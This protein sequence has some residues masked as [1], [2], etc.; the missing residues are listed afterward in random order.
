[1]FELMALAFQTDS[2]RVISLLMGHDG[3]N[4]SFDFIGISEGHHDLSH[5]QNKEDRIEKVATIDLWY[6]QQ[7]AKLLKKLDSME[8]VDGNSLLHNSMIIYGS[9]NA[10]GNRHTHTDLPLIFAG[11]AG[12]Q[13]TPGRFVD[14][15]SVPLTNLYLTVAEKMGVKDLQRFGDSTGPLSNV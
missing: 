4:R 3:D 12:G 1:M 2:T 14:H 6:S 9:G 13:A 15:R 11:N 8:D 5:H 10:D 7:F